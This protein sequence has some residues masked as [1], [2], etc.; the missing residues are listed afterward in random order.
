MDRIHKWYGILL[1]VCRRSEA[2][3]SRGRDLLKKLSGLMERLQCGIHR[4]LLMYGHLMKKK[5]CFTAYCKWFLRPIRRQ[6]NFS[7]IFL[8]LLSCSP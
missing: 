3:E 7:S 6:C 2:Y 1:E 8:H 4:D 5:G